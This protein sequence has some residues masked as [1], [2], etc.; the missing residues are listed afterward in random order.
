MCVLI[1]REKKIEPI[2]DRLGNVCKNKHDHK[3]WDMK[4]S[5]YNE[6]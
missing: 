2:D 5:Y 3:E 6:H 1:W 4:L